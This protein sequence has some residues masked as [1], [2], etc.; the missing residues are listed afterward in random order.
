MRELEQIVD[1]AIQHAG[2]TQ[3]QLDGWH[4]SAAFDR[5]DGLP[6]RPGKVGESRLRKPPARASLSD[7]VRDRHAVEV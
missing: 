7:M 6:A 2:E 4:G 1:A 5:D 3:R